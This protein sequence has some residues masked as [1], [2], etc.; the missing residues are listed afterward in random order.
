MG[1]FRTPR[2]TRTKTFL[3]TKHEKTKHYGF[4]DCRK[5]DDCRQR[6]EPQAENERSSPGQICFC[7]RCP[8]LHHHQRRRTFLSETPWPSPVQLQ[9]PSTGAWPCLVSSPP[10]VPRPP[11]ERLCSSRLVTPSL[12]SCSPSSCSLPPP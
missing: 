6:V 4:H 10:W 11:P 1:N 3:Q 5:Q 8:H 12:L 9:R 7:P 2:R